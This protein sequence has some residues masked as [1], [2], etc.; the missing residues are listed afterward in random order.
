MA[1]VMWQGIVTVGAGIAVGFALAGGVLRPLL[2][3]T[4]LTDPLTMAA[5]GV[6]PKT[7]FVGVTQP[8]NKTK[9]G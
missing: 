5:S 1:P 9:T 6:S 8:K 4:N 3:D 2:F 7:F